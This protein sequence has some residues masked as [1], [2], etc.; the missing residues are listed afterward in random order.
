MGCCLSNNDINY[1]KFEDSSIEYITSR[2][3]G[4]YN[5]KIKIQIKDKKEEYNLKLYNLKFP[6]NNS[7]DKSESIIYN[8]LNY[9]L[10]KYLL[11]KTIKMKIIKIKK[12]NIYANIWINDMNFNEYIINQRLAVYNNEMIPV[13][14]YMYYEYGCEYGYNI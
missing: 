6:K 5:L 9:L 11:N 2:V 13:N 8:H 3:I 4:I 14:W 7:S 1:H 12:R 10:K